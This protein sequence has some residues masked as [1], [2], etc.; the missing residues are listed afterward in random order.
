MEI[1]NRFYLVRITKELFGCIVKFK[2]ILI[3]LDRFKS[4]LQ[5]CLTQGCSMLRGRSQFMVV[6]YFRLFLE[7]DL[8]FQT[9]M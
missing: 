6:I 3:T 5:Y 7:L 4:L 2:Y 9:G 8:V 1:Q